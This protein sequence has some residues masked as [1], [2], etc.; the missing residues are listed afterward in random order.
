MT[1]EASGLPMPARAIRADDQST[2]AGATPRL[3]Q[4][5]FTILARQIREGI[6]APGTRLSETGV[7]ARF[8]ISRAPARQALLELDRAGLVRKA[9]GRG[10]RVS[11]GEVGRR[12]QAPRGHA[13]EEGLLSSRPTWER[14]Y[15]EV[16][17]ELAAR[18]SF[19]GWQVIESSLARH[20][21]VSRTVARDV[22]GRLQQRGMIE[23]DHRSRW[24]APVLS[25]E[26]VGELYEL[27]SLLE[28][29]AL[30]KAAPNVPPRL[31]ATMRRHLQAAI[32]SPHALSGAT[33]DRLEEE[34]HIE[35]LSYCGN[36]TLLQAIS[37]PQ[38]LLIAH[39]FLYQWTPR[40]FEPEPFLSEHMAIV[41]SLRTGNAAQAAQE[42]E[43]HLRVSRER[44]IAR[45]EVIAGQFHPDDL[46]YLE[47]ARD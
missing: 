7:A 32:D 27:R 34:M 3:Y 15:A 39:R 28:P 18:T 46:P 41:E 37:L 43:A 24:Q 31:L 35:L 36:R 1:L 16:E 12:E 19:A 5:A 44:A 13:E 2:L 8:G 38:S 6:L 40:L 4:R 42:L 20:Y 22:L 47:R 9:A 21:G 17:R 25:P 26:R 33:L 14:L 23:K 11:D 10:Y 45:I 29:V 30:L